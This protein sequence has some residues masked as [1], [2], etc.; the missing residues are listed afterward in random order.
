MASPD[1]E[2]SIISSSSDLEDDQST[3]SSVKSEFDDIDVLSE[4]R[5]HGIDNDDSLATLQVPKYVKQNDG[6]EDSD[7]PAEGD[8]EPGTS[9]AAFRNINVSEK[10]MAAPESG[11]DEDSKVDKRETQPAEDKRISD[12]ILFYEDLNRQIKN[13]STNFWSAARSK[14]T[15]ESRNADREEKLL[16]TNAD[17][18][19]APAQ[20]KE[21]PKFVAVLD[22]NS[23]YLLHYLLGAGFALV[24]ALATYYVFQLTLQSAPRVPASPYDEL[25]EKMGK[26]WT[27]F[28]FQPEVRL[29]WYKQLWLK[30]PLRESKV[31]HYTALATATFH[32]LTEGISHRIAEFPLK[33]I[34]RK[35]VEFPTRVL[36]SR[37][38]EIPV[39]RMWNR[40]S[41]IP[42][43]LM[44]IGAVFQA[45]LVR[46]Y[47]LELVRSLPIDNMKN[48]FS[49][50]WN[51]ARYEYEHVFTN[52]KNSL[53][54][55]KEN[56]D[57]LAITIFRYG[58]ALIHQVDAWLAES[59]PR[60]VA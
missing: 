60:Y 54:A 23:E 48:L 28:M 39:K 32:R 20:R 2:W 26:M 6:S 47:G 37:V 40:V 9:D 45:K 13:K 41:E 36:W 16:S 21:H 50:T 12:V 42:L 17:V 7:R 18:Q 53:A 29:P 27:T 51:Q 33:L 38:S 55:L 44:W 57:S 5:N 34:W 56:L 4:P 14:L 35:F 10:A 11:K 49:T 30:K 25:R 3:Q 52:A 8:A 58:N 46:N 1:E 43:K 59:T 24:T 31:R 19:N 15:E 22:A